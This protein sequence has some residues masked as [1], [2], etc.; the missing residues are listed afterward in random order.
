MQHD[1]VWGSICDD[2]FSPSDAAVI[3]KQ[4]GYRYVND[5]I[6]KESN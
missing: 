4:L 3:C 1:G 6:L 5:H 2:G